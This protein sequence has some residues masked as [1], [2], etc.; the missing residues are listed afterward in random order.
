MSLL[1][2]G[3]P[4]VGQSREMIYNVH[5]FMQ[6]EA[7]EAKNQVFNKDRFLKV[8]ERTARATGVS[9]KTVAV[10]LNE[11]ELL[12]SEQ[13]TSG[14]PSFKTP[15]KG[16]R[17]QIHLAKLD[18][19]DYQIIRRKVY[20][21]L[22]CENHLPTV[23]SLLGILK[24]DINYNG[25]R[26]TLRKILRQLGFKF[27]KAQSNTKIL[28]EKSE[29][30]LVR[31][32][33][34]KQ[35]KQYRNEGRNIVYGDETFIPMTRGKEIPSTDKNGKGKGLIII[36]AGGTNGFVPGALMI[37][38][39]TQ[40]TG[41]YLHEINT[42]NYEKW[43]KNQL[44]PNL[45]SNSV[46]V[47]DNAAYHN[48]INEKLPSSNSRKSEMRDWLKNKNIEFNPSALK[49]ELYEIIKKHKNDYVQYSIDAIMEEHGHKVLRLPPYHPDFNPIENT[50]VLVK[51]YLGKHNTELSFSEITQLLNEKFSSINVEAWRRVIDHAIE[52]E[53]SFLTLEEV[54]DD[55][56][57]QFD[58][59]GDSSS[60]FSSSDEGDLYDSDD[61]GIEEIDP[62]S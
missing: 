10:V 62:L 50:W 29:V 30:R 23:K 28:V 3:R 53:D 15:K 57:D 55:H 44:I 21:F 45:T 42:E 59:S 12:S 35:I 4:I 48:A 2:R 58:I 46:F 17:K 40:S 22:M 41:D 19:Y 6:N 47:I 16:R 14:G 52:G 9:R 39:S 34:I 20:D 56:L 51:D 24:R 7:Q 27:K 13:S 1:K 54:I 37:Y 36:H 18:D 11:K 43:I 26:E 49:P 61:D 31:I 5:Q 25:E 32:K 33:Y 60:A 8:M 38:K